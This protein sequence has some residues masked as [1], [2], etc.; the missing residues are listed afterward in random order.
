M[1]FDETKI[2]SSEFSKST[3]TEGSTNTSGNTR[4]STS[5]VENKQKKLSGT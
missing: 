2:P 3:S 5:K 1:G 4:G